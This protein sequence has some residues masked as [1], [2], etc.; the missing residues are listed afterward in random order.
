MIP[1]I[2]RQLKISRSS[3]REAF[4]E[5]ESILKIKDELDQ[6]IG[7]I[8]IDYAV[9]RISQ[10]EKNILRLAIYEILHVADVPS[11]VAISEAVRLSRKFGS[12]SSSRFV[13]AV[14]DPI[15]KESDAPE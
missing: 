13:N 6:K 8:S 3:A 5:A 1:M 10:I 2:M 12:P 15:L 14:L 11:K 9:E 7:A 4:E